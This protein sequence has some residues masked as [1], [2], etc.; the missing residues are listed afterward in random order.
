MGKA[1]QK[2]GKNT[3][4]IRYGKKSKYKKAFK[5]VKEYDLVIFAVDVRIDRVIREDRSIVPPKKLVVLIR[6]DVFRICRPT[7]LHYYKQC[8]LMS[9][10]I[11]AFMCAN[12]KMYEKFNQ[13]YTNKSFYA[14]GGVDTE[15]FRPFK[16]RRRVEKCRVG[17]AGSKARGNKIRGLGIVRKACRKAGYR[18]N[19]AIKENKNRSQAEMVKYYCNEIDIYVDASITAGRQNGLL[20]AAACGTP[21]AC[22]RVGIGGEL[23]DKGLATE[24]K[25]T[26]G[27]VYKAI[28]KLAPKRGKVDWDLVKNIRTKWSW[29]KH[30]RIWEDILERIRH[31]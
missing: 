28:K 6:S 18:W 4:D 29:R 13:N 12:Q 23:V 8:G 2:Y 26:P 19:P 15:I 7:R 3:Y 25:R 5:G 22:T 20:E 21:I 14:P 11:R 30:V 9:Q 27:S 17:W 10:K 16:K 24:I 1:L 31:G